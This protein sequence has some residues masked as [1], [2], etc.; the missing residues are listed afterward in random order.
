LAAWRR[1]QSETSPPPFDRWIVHAYFAGWP[2]GNL[3]EGMLARARDVPASLSSSAPTDDNQEAFRALVHHALLAGSPTEVR[4]LQAKIAAR[5]DSTDPSDPQPQSLRAALAARL[6]LLARDTAAAIGQLETS[7]ARPAQP[8]LVFY[9][10]LSMGPERMLLAE[11]YR[12]RGDTAAARRWLDSPTPGHLA[13]RCTLTALPVCD[14]SSP[15]L[16]GRH[17]REQRPGSHRHR[18]GSNPKDEQSK[19]AGNQTGL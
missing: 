7:V 14:A 13:M 1:G 17:V 16:G 11:L 6:A 9:P 3:A 19:V 12:A 4:R 15:R 10:Q 2:V 18:G 8:F 5:S